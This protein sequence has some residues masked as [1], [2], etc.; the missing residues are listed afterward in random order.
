[1][2]REMPIHYISNATRR[3]ADAIV[4][5]NVKM[6][7]KVDSDKIRKKFG[8]FFLGRKDERPEALKRYSIKNRV[9]P[10]TKIRIDVLKLIA[11]RYR[12]SNQVALPFSVS[13]S[14]IFFFIGPGLPSLMFN[15][16][17]SCFLYHPPIKTLREFKLGFL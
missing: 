10:E 2:G 13:A 14:M 3:Q 7:S 4:I 6:V 8:S 17:G 15:G 9:T 12:D 16:F 1:M 11:Q 5:Y